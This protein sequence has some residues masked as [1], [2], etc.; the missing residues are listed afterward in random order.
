M[1]KNQCILPVIAIFDS[2]TGGLSIYKKIKKYI[3]HAQYIYI[4]DNEGFPYG[5]RSKEFIFNRVIKIITNIHRLYTIDLTI[6]ACNTASIVAL[7]YLKNK[8]LDPIIGVT[9]EINLAMSYTKN[10]VI[11]FLG[12]S[13]TINNFPLFQSQSNNIKIITL[14]AH[15]LILLSEKKMLGEYISFEAIHDFFLPFIQHSPIPDTIILGCTHLSLLIPEIIK[16]FPKKIK[17]IDSRKNITDQSHL[18]L[19]KILRYSRITKSMPGIAYY[20]NRKIL[21][22]SL[23]KILNF[24]NFKVLKFMNISYS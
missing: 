22:K 3:P 18:L 10:K 7:P 1:N 14:D 15:K 13:V 24:Y 20:T 17:L 2:G 4:L 6:L 21:L 11:G 23:H 19:S 8:L 5:K 12:T 9:P 16:I